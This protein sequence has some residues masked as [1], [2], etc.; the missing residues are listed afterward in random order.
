M[1]SIVDAVRIVFAMV[2]VD[3]LE[4]RVYRLNSV[5]RFGCAVILRLNFK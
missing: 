4:Y 3:L 5:N 2:V 1:R